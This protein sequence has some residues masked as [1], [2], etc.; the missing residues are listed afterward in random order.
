MKVIRVGDDPSNETKPTSMATTSKIDVEVSIKTKQHR[1]RLTMALSSS[2]AGV[3][4]EK[5]RRGLRWADD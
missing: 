3:G 4:G 1:R 5:G 2:L